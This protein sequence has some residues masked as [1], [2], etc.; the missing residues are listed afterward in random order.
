MRPRVRIGGLSTS[1]VEKRMRL[2]A[3]DIYTYQR[4]SPCG[5]RVYLKARGEPEGEPSP[6][7]QVL[8]RLG[9]RHEQAHLATFPSLLDLRPGTTEER[10]QRTLA[11]VR[12]KTLVIYQAVF[13]VTT[14]IGGAQCDIVGEPDF[15]IASNGG[16][17][18]RD[19]KMSRRITEQDHPEILRQM[20]LYG[21][22]F[23]QQCGS[24]PAAL[25]VHAGTGEIVTVPYDGGR[26]ALDLLGEILDL[27]QAAAEPYSPVGWTKCSGCGFYE[28]CW[29]RAEQKRDAALV[30]GVDQGLAIALR[31]QGIETVDQLLEEFDESR[32]AAFQRPWGKKTQRVGTKAASILRMARAMATGQEIVLQPP[33]VPDHPNY[34]MFDLEG[35]P[36]QLDELDKIYLWGLRVFGRNPGPFQAATAGFGPDGDCQGWTDFLGIAAKVL[37]DHGDIPFVHWASYEKTKL[38]AYIT[39][40]GD[41]NGVGA[42][43]RQN[44]LDLLPI[45]QA[46]IA[47]PLPSYSLKVVEQY[48]G[49]HRTQ[50]EYGGDWAMAKYIEAT[51]I[52]DEKERAEV[53][54]QILAYNREDLEAMWAVLQWLKVKRA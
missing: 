41:P 45:T 50:E 39:R 43:V 25:Q 7:E 34:V 9:E 15:L 20:G 10:Q 42:R 21:W 16:Y 38:S 22:L 54:E 11:A 47:L 29:P 30:S 48:V 28:R 35:L 19:S 49:Y 24:P 44:L 40:Y 32:L 3:S 52:E 33:A 4:P 6:Y 23:Q 17:A 13:R 53:M 36:P 27:K 2:T 14:T 18:I 31:Q 26:A 1:C 12:Q 51:E 46:S 8:R 5:A 37:Q